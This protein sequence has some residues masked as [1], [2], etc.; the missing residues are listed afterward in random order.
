[1]HIFRSAWN[2]AVMGLVCLSV[3]PAAHVVEVVAMSSPIE[4]RALPAA[5]LP[6]ASPSA[7]K[8][9]VD[10]VKQWPCERSPSWT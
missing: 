3:S 9:A 10:L 6:V 7:F 4:S 2:C 1:M 8:V 5:A